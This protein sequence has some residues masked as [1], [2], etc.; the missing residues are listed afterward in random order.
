MRN[1]SQRDHPGPLT[2]VKVADHP[3]PRGEAAILMQR[4]TMMRYGHTL[5]MTAFAFFIMPV[6]ARATDEQVITLTCDGL[7]TTGSGRTEQVSKMGVIVSFA[8]KTLAFGGHVVA[9]S[10]V[11]AAN[12]SFSGH[13]SLEEKTDISLDG[14]VDRVTG[15]LHATQSS[16]GLSLWFDLSCKPTDRLF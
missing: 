6:A 14:S 1:T 8:E 5:T 16:P 7:A 13:S 3:G 11:D 4:L 9:I 2:Y 10:R 15:T 12:V